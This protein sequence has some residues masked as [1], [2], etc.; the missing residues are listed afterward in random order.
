MTYSCAIFKGLDGDLKMGQR[1]GSRLLRNGNAQIFNDCDARSD[2]CIHHANRNGDM[3]T[4]THGKHVNGLGH[5]Q[6]TNQ[7]SQGNGHPADEEE[8]RGSSEDDELQEAQMRKLDHIINK[9]RIQ[10]G[11]RV[12]EI[13]SG[14]GS[15]A[16]RITQTIPGTTVDTITLSVQQQVLAQKRISA[17]GLTDRITVHLMDYRKM[18]SNWEGAFDRLISIEMLEAV[19]EAF[20]ET[21]WSIVEWALKPLTGAGVV[22]VITIPETSMLSFV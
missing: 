10:P 6:R 21:Y 20:L 13:G 4:L 9:A 19:G 12:L 22:Q 3:D 15:M 7:D 16:I 18:P 11:H 2:V 1:E 5:V 8:Y 14:W 17:L